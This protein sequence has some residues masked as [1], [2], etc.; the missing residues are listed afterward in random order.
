MKLKKKNGPKRKK[1]KGGAASDINDLAGQSGQV[2]KG[3]AS[4]LFAIEA[5]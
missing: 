3:E 2:A 1:Q 4:F 5:C